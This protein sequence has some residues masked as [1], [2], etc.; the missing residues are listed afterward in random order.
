MAVPAY[1][2]LC[3]IAQNPVCCSKMNPAAGLDHGAV[4]NRL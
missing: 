4:P 2:W 1:L 3:V